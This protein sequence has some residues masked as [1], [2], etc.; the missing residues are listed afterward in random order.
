MIMNYKHGL[1][2]RVVSI[3]VVG[4]LLISLVVVS[5]Y[6]ETVDVGTIDEK[7]IGTEAEEISANE[8]KG[9]AEADATEIPEQ[10]EVTETAEQ[11]EDSFPSELE[12][13]YDDH[14]DMSGRTVE[15][16]SA[17]KPTSFRV[18]YDIEEGTPDEAVVSLEGERLV[19]VGIG[20]AQITVDEVLCDVTVTAAP[21]SLL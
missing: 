8:T 15:I 18:G 21:I 20:T 3:L 11:A 10:T 9:S 17:G 14:M 16:V 2:K 19:A 4:T 1:F 6:G 5:G 12:M 13:R 7:G